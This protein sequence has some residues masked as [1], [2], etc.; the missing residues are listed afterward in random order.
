MIKVSKIISSPGAT[1]ITKQKRERKLKKRA[2]EK[3][4]LPSYNSQETRSCLLASLRD[5]V[6]PE[7]VPGSGQSLGPVVP[8]QP[9]RY[10]S[11]GLKET[12]LKY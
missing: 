3:A 12:V 5:P 11:I 1:L 2:K 8:L 10:F 7:E 6:R 9:I 4:I